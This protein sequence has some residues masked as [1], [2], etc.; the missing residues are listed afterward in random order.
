MPKRKHFT[1]SQK[2]Q[3][4]L[5]ILKEKNIY[6]FASEVGVHPNILYCWKKQALENL[7]IPA[8]PATVYLGTSSS[9]TSSACIK[10]SATKRLLSLC[11]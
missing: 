11:C 10:L 7:P 8:M 9:T 3:I 5:E 1:A 6:Q 4:V 2:A